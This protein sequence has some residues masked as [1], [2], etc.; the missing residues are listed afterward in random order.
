VSD[1][2]LELERVSK[3]Y[4]DRGSEVR[5]V[6]DVSLAIERGTTLALVGESGSGKST[7]ARIALWL[8]E[9]DRGSVRLRAESGARAVELGSLSPRALRAV[10][11][12]LAVVFQDPKSSLD[13][14]LAVRRSVEEPLL[15]H[16]LAKGG[17]LARRVDGL[18]SRVGID[19]S[20][21]A[22]FPHQFSIGQLQR[23][24]IA[25]ALAAGPKLIVLD[26]PTSALD[27]SLQAQILNLLLELQR[28]LGLSY[29]FVSH[30]LAVVRHVA[31]RTAVMH[32]GSIV[33]ER[34]TLELFADPK[35]DHTRELLRAWSA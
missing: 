23:I 5:A 31:E 7:L 19:P 11:R 20:R 26:E 3:T 6:R 27:P 32:A 9:P 21:G 29:L 24:A 10:R 30:D 12:D 22:R 13:A 18:L 34:P 15:V 17:E 16:G 33:E 8:I 25:R 35:A 14:R 4:R 2:I 1:P 28:E